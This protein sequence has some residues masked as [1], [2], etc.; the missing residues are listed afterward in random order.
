ME[1]V[2]R[3]QKITDD[4]LHILL[5]HILSGIKATTT[6]NYQVASYMIVSQLSTRT[7]FTHKLLNTILQTVAKYASESTQADALC[8]I[9]FLCQTQDI[10]H[11]K[12]DVFHSLLSF[13]SIASLISDL[14]QRYE[15]SK[16]IKLFVQ[17]LLKNWYNLFSCLC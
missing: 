17:A 12:D 14:S 8:C 16:F 10:S 7:P 15:T 9:V 2:S 3:A 11:F 6:R 4:L 5:P 1:I 13:R